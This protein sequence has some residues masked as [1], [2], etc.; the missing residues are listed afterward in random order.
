[1]L[2]RAAPLLTG[3]QISARQ[4][5]HALQLVEEEENACAKLRVRFMQLWHQHAQLSVRIRQFVQTV[6]RRVAHNKLT[7]WLSWSTVRA[8]IKRKMELLSKSVLLRAQR[9]MLLEWHLWSCEY[10]ELITNLTIAEHSLVELRTLRALGA[11][12]VY[13][14]H[15]AAQKKAAEGRLHRL[16]LRTATLR[17][18]A[19]ASSRR[20]YQMIVGCIRHSQLER[21]T[22]CWRRAPVVHRQQ[23]AQLEAAKAAW[24]SR[25]T[26]AAWSRW[27]QMATLSLA[28]R[29]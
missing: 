3:R 9:G 14:K 10:L 5:Q 6:L 29:R 27:Q 19:W 8:A 23:Q 15:S 22:G 11:M 2:Q 28:A 12:R 4:E 25:Q 7:Q 21:S 20:R 17:L 1:M 24:G 18:T 26:A 13:A 16:L